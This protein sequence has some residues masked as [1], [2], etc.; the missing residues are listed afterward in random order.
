MSG[1]L[2]RV[3]FA[4][5]RRPVAA[6][7]IVVA[8]GLAGGA[9]AL[10]LA[11]TTGESTFVS[12]G[13]QAF[14]ATEDFHRRFGDDAIVV[15]IQ[16]KL[17]NLVDSADL[18]RLIAFEGCLG[19]NIPKGKKAYAPVCEQLARLKPVKVVYGPGTF[20]NEAINAISEQFTNQ[21]QQVQAAEQQAGA[22]AQALA[23]KRHYGKARTQALVQQAEQQVA[24]QAISQLSQ[25]A[26]QSGINGLPRLDN[27]D[28][29]NQ[30]VFDA[31]RGSYVPKARFAYLFPSGNAALIQVRLKADL[32]ESDRAKA[33]SLIRQAAK[34]V[35]PVAVTASFAKHPLGTSY[36]AQYTVT[37]VPV[38]T[39]DLAGSVTDSIGTFLL[40]ALL[41][42]AL[43]LVVVFRA[44]LRLLP[45]AIALA[46]A[47]ITF[48]AM[49]LAGASL[50]MASVAVLPVLIGLAVD[51]AIQ[52][53]ARSTEADALPG[54]GAPTVATAALATAAGFLALLLSPVPMV[55]GF[56]LLLVLGIL[57][58]FLC[59]LVAV[60]AALAL[61]AQPE[62]AGRLG[63]ALR[64]LGELVGS[65][66]RGAGDLLC[67]AGRPAAGAGAGAA[68]RLGGAARSAVA[69]T[70]AHPRQV[71]AIGL[72]LAAAGWAA[73]TQTHVESD[74]RKLV[75]QDMPALRDVDRL[76]QATKI[77]GEIDVTVRAKD[78]TASA[79]L[80]WMT[81]YQQRVLKQFGY[82]G[83]SGCGQ[84]RLCPALSLPDLF[85]SA[86]NAKS[87]APSAAQV[88]ALLAIIPPYFS[89][90]VITRDRT[91]ANLAFGIRLMPLGEQERVV[92]A[93]RHALNPPKGV[94]AQLAG[95]PVLAADANAKLSDSG[96]RLLTLAVSLLL[97]A[98][99]LLLVF[100][101]VRR[102]L[103]PLAPIVL[104]TGWSSGLL[105]CLRIPLNPM[106]ATLG[107]LVV[108]ISTEFSVLL[109]ERYRQERARGSSAAEALS[110]TYASTGAAVLA[111]GT[112]AILGFAV[113]A[114]SSITMLR[115][116]AIVTVVD[117]TVS[118][119][120]VLAVLPAVLAAAERPAVL[121]V[122]LRR[123]RLRRASAP[124][125]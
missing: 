64:G 37:G 120:G 20:L 23:R 40:A 78:V 125:G 95:L 15:L 91:E 41:A 122:R 43:T 52:L 28:L 108:A 2:M 31:T 97:V 61:R 19:G 47:G 42:M 8:L 71:L 102:A 56:G 33:I 48:G 83:A 76:E 26:L 7:L 104:A 17:T 87:G 57:L 107:A 1:L 117:L 25:L 24:S 13:S 60:P 36:G 79:V 96:R 51:Y 4:A 35:K 63:P 88:R 82:A 77:S 14:K 59:A 69:V 65:A 109:A 118:L 66:V 98:F 10:R 16:E 90:S 44:R 45:L 116:F 114:A 99:A 49:E 70:A 74:V 124:A 55:R 22:Q 94:T 53:Q 21:L 29:I 121:R 67:A 50:T 115:N 62:R 103:V 119:L 110:R 111:S 73:D 89:Q 54:A 46:A 30:I 84:A 11:P 105:F 18:G 93:M 58:A 113:L 100:R 9:L 75:P 106:S 123:P 5:A 27:K 72:V 80:K 34:L 6:L 12:S 32:T 85:S 39:N 38:V 3:S 101:D 81:G 92:A 68:R 86:T 112:T